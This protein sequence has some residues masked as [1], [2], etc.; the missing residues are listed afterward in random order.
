MQDP[1]AWLQ[2]EREIYSELASKYSGLIVR[3][4]VWLPGSRS[5]VLR[6]IDVLLEETLPGGGVV[7]AI[8]AKHHARKIDVKQVE[9]FLGLLRDVQVDRGMMISAKG[10]TKTAMGPTLCRPCCLL[11]AAKPL[12]RR[13]RH[14]TWIHVPPTLL[15]RCTRPFAHSPVRA[16]TNSAPIASSDRNPFW[17]GVSRNYGTN[18]HPFGHSGTSGK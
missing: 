9:A 1:P 3:H 8:D 7:T 6:Q 12:A 10:Y 11:N 17:S 4:N 5:G 15:A 2:Y 13:G 18:L 14:W 16:L